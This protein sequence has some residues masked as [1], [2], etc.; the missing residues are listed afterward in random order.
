MLYSF[1]LFLRIVLTP[2]LLLLLIVSLKTFYT[3]NFQTNPDFYIDLCTH[4][5]FLAF[6]LGL[7]A[8]VLLNLFGRRWRFS[9]P[10][11]FID[12]LEHELTHALFGYVT[13]SPPVSLLA[14][15]E[16]GGEV[17]LK[18]TNVLVALSPYFFPLWVFLAVGL[19]FLIKASFLPVWNL[20]TFA[21][22]GSFIFR[23]ATEFRWY[24]NDLKIYG[25]IFSIV[26]A[27]LLFLISFTVILHLTDVLNWQWAKA[28]GGE[29]RLFLDWFGWKTGTAGVIIVNIFNYS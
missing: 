14:T 8:R 21:L 20:V 6:A 4:P 28:I 26:L 24:Q 5:C 12:T 11:D 1:F 19:G 2:V 16:A 7:S 3:V 23:V 9:N 18:R 13:F 22:F 10:L 27:G 15:L 29:L 25:R 17:R